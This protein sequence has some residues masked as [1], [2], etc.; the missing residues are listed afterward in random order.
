VVQDQAT[1]SSKDDGKSEGGSPPLARIKATWRWPNRWHRGIGLRLVARVLV[2]SSA[3]TLL[4]TLLQLYFDYRRDVGTIDRQISEIERSYGR[5]L[6]EGLWNLDARQLELQVDGILHLP[7]IR[8]VE[9]REATDR[10]DP[11]MVT[12][13]S[14]QANADVH[15]EFPIFHMNRGAEQ[16]LGVLSIEAT[17]DDVYHRLFHTAIVILISQGAKTFAVAFFILYIVNRLITRHLVAAAKF[18]GGYDL[19]RSPPP[20][21]LERRPLQQVDEL[22]QLVGAFNG[23]CVE[24]SRLFRDLEDREGKIRRLV[25]ANI[26]GICIWNLEGAIVGA[27][28]AFLHMLQYGRED[29]VSGRLRWTDLTPAEWREQDER[30]V[31][32]LRSNGTFQP[33]EKEYFRKDGNRIPVLIG[34]ALFQDGGNEGVA[35]VLDLSEQKR[36]E[37]ALRS[38]EAYLAEAQRLSQTGSW[39]WSPDQDIRYWSE[40]CYRVLSFDPQDGLP[41]FGQFFQRIHPDDQPGFRELIQTAIR[42]KAEWEAD[43]RIVHPGGAVRDIHVVGHPVLSTSGHLVEFVGTVIDVTESKRA[44]EEL[45]GSEME[46]R[47]ML[48]LAPQQVAVFGPG[49]ERL[50]ANRILLDY[51]GLTLEEWRQRSDRDE[52]VHPDDWERVT[53]HFDCA[54]T[55]GAG[56]ELE[57]RLRKG[58]GRYRW[59][60]VRYNPVRDDHGH[61]TRWFSTATDI[62]DRKRAEERLQQENV[63]LRE[64]IDK[65][66]MFE[67]IVGASPALASVLS[68]VSKVARSDSTALIMGETGTGKELVARAIHRRSPRAARPFVSVNCAAVPRELIASELFGHEKGAFTGATQRRLGRF[69]LAHGGTIFLDEVGELP[70]ETQVALLR[71]LQEHEFER[72]GGS[73]SIRVDARVVAAT[74]RDLQ[75]AIEAGTFRSDLFYRL[76]VFPVRVPPLRERADDIPLLVEYFIDRYGRKAGKSIRRVN[77]RTLDRLQSYPWPGNVR[78]L[79]NVIERSVIVCDTDEFTVDE[80]WLSAGPAVESRLALSSTVAAHEKATIEEALR[81]SGGRVF[82]PS[83]AAARLGIARSTLESKIRALGIN[84]NRFR[85]RP[86]K[87]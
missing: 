18:L 45:R 72:V 11:M 46:L 23:M 57:L 53:R 25:D 42:E 9:V 51:L 65:A 49:R 30:A 80:S 71:V 70:M 68:R 81:A 40:E 56:F 48:D 84:K 16:T 24:N 78:E 60:L 5:S 37:E 87:Q 64:E 69:E 34:G 1:H 44:E 32:E 54:L 19:R 83:G 14:H 26:L 76:N 12:A 63:A 6:G 66:S 62:D 8:F 17:L 67:E 59:F 22:D 39:A 20:L 35:F 50:Y 21:R 82:G 4:L 13:G 74:N 55:S 15:R 52:F 79:Q 41:R 85:G 86:A 75:A 27:N 33:F 10:A 3:I 38:S 77:K 29:V 36:A 61:I 43:Y 73:A 47:Q 7:D 58:D 2:F 31:A 28:E